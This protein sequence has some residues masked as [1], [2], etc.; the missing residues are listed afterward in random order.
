M[1]DPEPQPGDGPEYDAN[2]RWWEARQP[3]KTIWD[4]VQA[5]RARADAVTRAAS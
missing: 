2:H 1:S 4:E 3:M 5:E